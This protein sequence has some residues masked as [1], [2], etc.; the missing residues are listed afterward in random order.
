MLLT[1]A[2]CLK[3]CADGEN[4]STGLMRA[5][6]MSS[7]TEKPRRGTTGFSKAD[8]SGMRAVSATWGTLFNLLEANSF[9]GPLGHGLKQEAG[10][11]PVYFHKASH[12]VGRGLLKGP[13]GWAVTPYALLTRLWRNVAL[14][15]LQCEARMSELLADIVSAYGRELDPEVPGENAPLFGDPE[16]SRSD[17]RPSRLRAGLSPAAPRPRSPLQRLLI[18]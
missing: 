11:R 17:R 16:F 9:H 5:T 2:G 12:R 7:A 14:P 10:C 6:L 3:S 15:L 1:A 4:P 8:A 18:A 13:T